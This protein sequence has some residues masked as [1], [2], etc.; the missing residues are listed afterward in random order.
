MKH[1]RPFIIQ[2]N[3]SEMKTDKDYADYLMSLLDNDEFKKA[4]DFFWNNANIKFKGH[5][6]YQ[7][8][9]NHPKFD[10]FDEEYSNDERFGEYTDQP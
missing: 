5:T 6:V 1:L 4:S 2:E 9:K 10:K 8:L 7:I 3:I